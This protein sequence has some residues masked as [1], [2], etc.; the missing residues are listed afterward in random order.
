MRIGDS[1]SR[2]RMV[3]PFINSHPKHETEF[4][5]NSALYLQRQS[6][7]AAT[8]NKEFQRLSRLGTVQSSGPSDRL[9]SIADAIVDGELQVLRCTCRDHDL[10][11]SITSSQSRVIDTGYRR[12]GTPP[13]QTIG[14]RESAAGVVSKRTSCRKSK[15]AAHMC[16]GG[17]RIHTDARQICVSCATTH[18]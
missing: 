3:R 2:Q 18:D 10:S 17:C 5:M 11:R 13:T 14:R 1:S 8:G 16:N 4:P 7:T 9:G 15:S 12:I 6:R